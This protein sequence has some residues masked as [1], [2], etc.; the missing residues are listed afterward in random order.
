MKRS[1]ERFAKSNWWSIHWNISLSVCWFNPCTL[2]N[3]IMKRARTLSVF[4]WKY[5][6][7][8]R[9]I[10]LSLFT[11]ETHSK[12]L[13]TIDVIN[14]SFEYWKKPSGGN[15]KASLKNRLVTGHVPGECREDRLPAYPRTF[16]WFHNNSMNTNSVNGSSCSGNKLNQQL[17]ERK[18]RQLNF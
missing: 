1:L 16:T 5:S 11:R 14:E 18:S 7:E 12:Y 15:T 6:S 3:I 17:A 4:T 2:P 9:Q 10:K 13:I 8:V